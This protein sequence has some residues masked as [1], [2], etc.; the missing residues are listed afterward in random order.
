MIKEYLINYKQELLEKKIDLTKALQK[1]ELLIKEKIEFKRLIELSEDK[2]YESFSPQNYNND[3]NKEQI[4]ELKNQQKELEEKKV[5]LKTEIEAINKKIDELECI[6]KSLKQLDN[7]TKHM[8]EELDDNEVFRL[9]LLETQEYERKRIARELHDSTV[10]SLT[11]MIH[12]LEFCTKLM[13]MD[14]SRCK[15]ELQNL[16]NT[17]RDTIRDMR[18]VIYNLRPMSLDDIGID[19]TIERELDRLRKNNDIEISCETIGNSED[20][21]PVIGLTML[22]IIQEAC[23]NTIKH[24]NA[25]KINIQIY[26][27]DDEI[28]MKIED[29]GCGFDITKVRSMSNQS[30][31]GFGISIMYERVY[32]LSGTIKI[33]SE[34]NKGTKINITI[35]K[36]EEE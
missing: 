18:E 25:K 17:V 28:Q 29:D 27:K 5:Q 21:L 33:E 6:L 24:A 14:P 7:E 11:S 12:K 4:K 19:V 15:I 10:Q 20:I 35:P 22:R 13:D 30:D 9:K 31:S 2:S 26:Y 32:L 1:N 8:K 34:K 3:K 23:N 16:S 36:K